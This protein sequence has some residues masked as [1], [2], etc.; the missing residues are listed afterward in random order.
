MEPATH[1]RGGIPAL[2]AE[3]LRV[4][5]LFPCED[6]HPRRILERDDPRPRAERWALD[7]YVGC[8]FGCRACAASEVPGAR[9]S[10]GVKVEA[11]ALL[12]REA[13]R[14][15]LHARPILIGRAG[16]PYP[17]EEGRRRLTRALL[18]ILARQ[19]GLR[20]ALATRSTLLLRD[21]DLLRALAA[22]SR[23]AVHLVVGSAVEPLA[24]RLDP[25]A[26][27]AEARLASLGYLADAGVPA[28]VAVPVLPEV[29]DSRESLRALFEAAAR[30]RAGWLTVAPVPLTP[31]IRRR[32]AEWVRARMPEKLPAYRAL[33]ASGVPVDP[34]WR[35]ELRATVAAL[36]REIALPGSPVFAAGGGV[37]LALPGLDSP[38]RAA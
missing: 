17:P 34:D 14:Y 9:A 26:P 27:A 7:A 10:L 13:G 22:R 11:A 16:D 15:D 38:S 31:E 36:R 8:V 12:A 20:L 19:R 21:L 37:Q 3:G 4:R 35:A 33:A 28:G 6:L 5:Q 1:P 23:F 29:N 18:A 25:F 30:F 32:V 2:V 24:R